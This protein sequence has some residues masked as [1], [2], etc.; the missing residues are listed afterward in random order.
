MTSDNPT[1]TE[2]E[3]DGE[4]DR[5]PEH[6]PQDG[7]PFAVAHQALVAGRS[8]LAGQLARKRAERDRLNREIKQLVQEDDKLVSALRPF[9][10]A[11]KRLAASKA[12][13]A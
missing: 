2:P 9:D 8:Q 11:A 4:P 6:Q 3:T 13:R 1:P 12:V 5:D 10:R 7:S